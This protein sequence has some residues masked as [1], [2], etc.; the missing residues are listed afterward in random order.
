MT[1]AAQSFSAAINHL[2]VREAWAREQFAPYAGKTVRLA[3]PLLALELRVR[4]DG[5]LEALPLPAVAVES[6][7]PSAAHTF[8]VTITAAAD[9][10]PAFAQGG[11]A[12]AMKH[13]RIDG[14]AEFASTIARLAEH[15]R[16]EPEED[17]ASLIGD[18]PAHQ[19]TQSARAALTQTRRAARNLLES[20]LEYV[21]DEDPQLVRRTALEQMSDELVSLRDTLA[22]LEKRIDRLD[23]ALAPTAAK[24]AASPPGRTHS[25]I[26]GARIDSDDGGLP[27]DR[28]R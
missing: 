18:A 21:L 15:L 19:L 22:R 17:L 16:W 12:A 24:P 6:D 25:K 2:L 20:A 13:V 10:L 11:Q 4:D 3:T 14:D 23:R 9:A 26:D 8:D 1:L 27:S 28:S 5:L 7:A